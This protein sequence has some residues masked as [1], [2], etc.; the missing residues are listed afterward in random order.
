[1]FAIFAGLPHKSYFGWLWVAICLVFAALGGWRLAYH[2]HM[3]DADE[4]GGAYTP[5]DIYQRT[6]KRYRILS[7]V[8]AVLAAVLGFC[9]LWWRGLP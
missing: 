4:Y 7:M 6:L 5:P 9:I 3:W 1:M 8:Y 2:L